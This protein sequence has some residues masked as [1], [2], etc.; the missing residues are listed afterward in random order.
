MI[1]TV[2]PE[3]TSVSFSSIPFGGGSP[4]EVASMARH[5]P[6]RA[7]WSWSDARH[8]LGMVNR[9]TRRKRS[10]GFI[11]REEER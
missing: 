7:A 4:L 6:W 8:K 2:S 9:A 5:L 10:V 1:D 11:V 3:K